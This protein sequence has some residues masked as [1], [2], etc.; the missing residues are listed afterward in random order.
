[1]TAGEDP[2]WVGQVEGYLLVAATREEGRTAAERFCASLDAWL[3]ETQREE[4]ERRFATEY[5]ALARR[6]WERT[7]RRAEEL[8]GEYEERYRALRCRLMA[9][10]LL[11]GVGLAAVAGILAV[12]R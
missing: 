2:G 7:A 10:G 4:V 6:S 3:T 12:I 11:V 8:R 9:A 1:M 5:A